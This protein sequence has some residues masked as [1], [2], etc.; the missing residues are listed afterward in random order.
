MTTQ[1][2]GLSRT[3][4]EQGAGKCRSRALTRLTMFWPVAQSPKLHHLSQIRCAEQS[5][6]KLV[7]CCQLRRRESR[8]RVREYPI[9]DV[10]PGPSK[11]MALFGQ[12]MMGGSAR[13]RNTFDESIL[14]HATGE[15]AEGLVTLK[16]QLGQEVQGSS[17]VLVEMPESVPLHKA[18]S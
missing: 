3:A 1:V 4:I 2:A 9:H 7:K 18:D 13:T 6:Q 11:L 10:F 5:N 15:R 14:N 12:T 16:R 17:R 8:K